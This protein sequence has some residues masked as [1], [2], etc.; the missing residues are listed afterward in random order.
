MAEKFKITWRV[1]D[2]VWMDDARFQEFA[3]T[4]LRYGNTADEVACFV[5]EPSS[6]A[7]DPLDRVSRE[8]EVFRRRASVLRAAGK[9]VG[10]N[11]WPTFGT[12]SRYSKTALRPK[13]PFPKMVGMD[14]KTDDNLV[15]PISPEFLEYARK[16][17]TILAQ[18]A[19]DF[20]W[21]DDDTRFTDLEGVAYPCF[22][23][24]CVK[25]F[26]GG[27]FADRETLVAALNR[28]ENGA[29]RRSWSAYGADRLA[30]FCAEVR[31]AVDE[32]DPAIDLPFMTV[33]PTHT[34]Y[35]GDFIEKC[36]KALRSRRGRPGH[37]FY[38]DEK[39]DGMLAKCMEAGWQVVRYPAEVSEIHYEEESCPC[40][41][42]DKSVQARMDEVSLA[43]MAGCSGVAFN[44]LNANPRMPELLEKEL[45]TIHE[46]R[47]VWEKF[48]EFAAGLGWQG[49]WP[50]FH[51]F[52]MAGMD[53]TADGWFHEYNPDYDITP[54]L[55]LGKSCLPLTCDWKSACGAVFSGKTL[56]A[57]T[58]QELEKIFSGSVMMDSDALE[59]LTAMGLGFLAGV[60][61]GEKR[62][63]V[64]EKLT[65][66]PFNGPFAGFTHNGIYKPA[67]ALE[68]LDG[69]A[70]SLAVS[71]DGYGMT[72][73]S[74]LSKYE[75]ELGGKVVV[76]GYNPWRFIGDPHKLWQL[77]SIAGWMGSPLTV[78]WPNPMKISQL[79][80]YIRGD[81][82]KAAVLLVNASLDASEPAELLLTG[83][84]TRAESVGAKGET[85]ALEASREGNALC[86]KIPSIAPWHI[87]TILAE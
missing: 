48:T 66:H 35:A 46:M 86:V 43:L 16:K 31:A 1:S 41:Y 42:L 6:G 62:I 54:P 30:R 73:E 79:C 59:T 50:A 2:A 65:D 14:G 20:I 21:V 25:G 83:G 23:E 29:L 24:H 72:Y 7:C 34:T 51:P 55:R 61:T 10:F 3:D 49:F 58:K 26:E 71:A 56:T 80:P 18:A 60:R 38:Y 82:R 85:L 22:C 28:P 69:K 44:H 8:A 5:A 70:E 17:Y 64:S 53:C 77:R 45:D 47:P 40:V 33:G 37:G 11:V 15:C 9:A 84:M 74:C 67:V 13:V 57:F 32:V 36:M 27:R 76:F 12:G 68:P 4:I 75:N 39:P 52:M 78:R 63:G 81:G 19:P 87:L